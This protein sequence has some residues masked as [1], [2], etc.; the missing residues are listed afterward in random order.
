MWLYTEEHIFDQLKTELWFVKVRESIVFCL[1]LLLTQFETQNYDMLIFI[2][3]FCCAL[4]HNTLIS[5]G[6]IEWHGYFISGEMTINK[7]FKCDEKVEMRVTHWAQ[8]EMRS[9][10]SGQSHMKSTV[11]GGIYSFL[12]APFTVTVRVDKQ[13]FSRS[14]LGFRESLCNMWF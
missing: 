8:L 11:S 7:I 10:T 2:S 6:N 13:L 4:H 9:L 14:V 3:S 12:F 1:V 5:Q